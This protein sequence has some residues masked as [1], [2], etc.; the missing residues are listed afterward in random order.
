MIKKDIIYLDS[1]ATTLKPIDV[2][3]EV[4]DYYEN[5]SANAHRGDYD[6]SAIVD[7]KYEGVRDKVKEAGIDLTDKSTFLAVVHRLDD[8]VESIGLDSCKLCTYC[9]NGKE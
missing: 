8:L 7:A 2:I 4:K 9:F 5:Y 3:N 1:C 6:I